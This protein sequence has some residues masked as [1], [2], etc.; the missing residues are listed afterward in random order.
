MTSPRMD[1]LVSPHIDELRRLAPQKARP[2]RISP[3]GRSRE[4]HSM[5]GRVKLRLGSYLVEIG[6]RLLFT[7]HPHSPLA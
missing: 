2:R 5:S 7:S 6:Q 3:Y 1:Q 4:R